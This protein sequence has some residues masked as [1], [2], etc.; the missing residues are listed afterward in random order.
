M[1]RCHMMPMH[2]EEKPKVVFQMK[3]KIRSTI[4]KGKA[5]GWMRVLCNYRARPKI[6]VCTAIWKVGQEYDDD[7]DEYHD[8][9]NIMMTLK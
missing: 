5:W 3:I 2:E 6:G 1:N 8:R 7:S 4:K 9:K